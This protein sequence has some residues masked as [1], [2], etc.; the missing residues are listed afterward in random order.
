MPPFAL[1]SRNVLLPDGL[2]DKVVVVH[3][4]RIQAIVDDPPQG[5]A[6]TDLGEQ[7]LMPGIVDT[8]VHVN[9]PGRTEWEGYE[10]ATRAAAAGG[11]TTLVDMPLNCIPVTT[12]T[13]AL[14]IKLDAARPRLWVDTAFWGGVIP[15]NAA[16]L[17]PLVRAGVLGAKAFMC[18]SGI[19]DFP[20]SDEDTLRTA[21]IELHKASSRLLVHAEL[22]LDADTSGDPRAYDTFLRSRPNAWEDEAI[23]LILRLCRETG[24]PVHIVHL[25]SA[26]ALPMLAR[27]RADGLPVT[28]E[29][30]PHYLCLEAEAVPDGD[31]AYKCCP[32]IREASNREALWKG[33]ADGIIDV[34]VTDHSPCTPHL[35]LPERGDF[36]DA[37]GGIASLQLGLANIW[38]EAR[39]RGFQLRDVS[40]WMSAAPARVSGLS[41]R[42]GCLAVGQDADLVLFD[43]DATWT[44]EASALFHR[45]KVTPYAGVE[46]R[47]RVMKTWLRGQVVW[48]GEGHRGPVGETVLGSAP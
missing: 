6:L 22:E 25:S 24:C 5:I 23:R 13:Q 15:G 43:P 19:D 36:L 2:A 45:H 31:T 4:G 34:V 27:A 17:G 39:R 8:H 47:G 44:V 29:T 30:C 48:D 18:Y 37:W 42:K 11:V 12:T 35:K 40:R 21:M 7:V 16:E 9:E 10:T 46:L 1:S 41:A 20:G 32:P 33:L 38:T 14:A 26:T 3:D 28:V